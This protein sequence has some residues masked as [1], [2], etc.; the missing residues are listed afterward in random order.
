MFEQKAGKTVMN[1]D[2]S[3]T[4]TGLNVLEL[5]EKAPGVA[6]DN[7]GN[8][9]LKGKNGVMILVDGKTDLLEWT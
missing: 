3:P 2:A 1:V 7:D 4:N 6:V 5:L 9:S 8:I